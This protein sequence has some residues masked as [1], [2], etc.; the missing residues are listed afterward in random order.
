MD[1]P[2]KRKRK[3]TSSSNTPSKRLSNARSADKPEASPNPRRKAK[4]AAD[5]DADKLWTVRTIQAEKGNKYLIDWEDDPVTGES[6]APTWEPKAY[7]N[8]EAIDDWEG[9]KRLKA[10]PTAMST[11]VAPSPALPT[12]PISSKKRQRKSES[13]SASASTTNNAADDLPSKE[14]PSKRARLSGG[15]G[16]KRDHQVHRGLRRQHSHSLGSSPRRA[17]SEAISAELPPAVEAARSQAS[18]PLADPYDNQEI[19]DSY[20]LEDTPITEELRVS[21][22]PLSK[23]D[24]P[25]HDQL[26][27]ASLPPRT[28]Q[29]PS[30]SPGLTPIATDKDSCLQ[31]TRSPQAGHSTEQLSLA[32]DPEGTVSD[33]H[34]VQESS[35]QL[36][37]PRSLHSEATDVTVEGTGTPALSTSTVHPESGS[38]RVANTTDPP[39]RTLASESSENLNSLGA[40]PPSSSDTFTT[41]EEAPKV[42][43]EDKTRSLS[44]P[45]FSESI[46]SPKQASDGDS[47]SLSDRVTQLEQDKPGES[48]RPTPDKSLTPTLD[49][50]CDTERSAASEP[51]IAE[52][53]PASVEA[54]STHIAEN[55]ALKELS[56]G[57]FANRQT[58]GASDEQTAEKGCFVL[59]IFVQQDPQLAEIIQLAESPYPVEELQPSDIPQTVEVEQSE[60]AG[61]PEPVEATR[62]AEDPGS[63]A[64]RPPVSS[65]SEQVPQQVEVPKPSETF[66]PVA[67]FQQGAKFTEPA[68][69]PQPA[70]TSLPAEIP[71]QTEPPEPPESSH[72]VESYNPIEA[73]QPVGFLLPVETSHQ[74]EPP[75]PLGYPQPAKLPGPGEAPTI[76]PA[77]AEPPGL[78]ESSQLVESLE[79]VD[80]PSPAGTPQL[81]ERSPSA[82][83]SELVRD[84]QPADN[85]PPLGA[86]HLLEPSRPVEALQLPGHPQL[87]AESQQAEASQTIENSLSAELHQSSEEP[88][89]V[90]VPREGQNPSRV[91]TLPP[92]EAPFPPVETPQPEISQQTEKPLLLEALQPVEDPILLDALQENLSLKTLQS[93]EI[94]QRAETETHQQAETPLQGQIPQRINSPR[95]VRA[96]E[97]VESP[98]PIEPCQLLEN[99]LPIA[100]FDQVEASGAVEVPQPTE[101]PQPVEPLKS[102]KIFQNIEPSPSWETSQSAEPSQLE[103][104]P[105]SLPISESSPGIPGGTDPTNREES[106]HFQ[107]AQNVPQAVQIP[108]PSLEE[109]DSDQDY[110]FQTQVPLPL[111]IERERRKTQSEERILVSS[112]QVETQG[113]GSTAA[114]ISSLHI[115]S[116]SPDK[117]LEISQAVEFAGNIRPEPENE[118]SSTAPISPLIT[119]PSQAEHGAEVGQSQNSGGYSWQAAQVVSPFT[120]PVSQIPSNDNDTDFSGIDNYITSQRLNDIAKPP[121]RH[122]IETYNGEGSRPPDTEKIQQLDLSLKT[123]L[124]PARTPSVVE[125][126]TKTV[127]HKDPNLLPEPSE[128]G[129]FPPEHPQNISYPDSDPH[130]RSPPLPLAPSQSFEGYESP[131]PAQTLQPSPDESMSDE[132]QPMGSSPRG[133]TLRE[134]L[135]SLHASRAAKRAMREES[136]RSARSTVSPPRVSEAQAHSPSPHS[137]GSTLTRVND[138]FLHKE[139]PTQIA[140]SIKAPDLGK[141]EFVVPLPINNDARHQYQQTINDHLGDIEAFL[142]AENE[143]NTASADQMKGIL[144]KISKVAI[145]P[146]LD[147][148][149]TISPQRDLGEDEAKRSEE[150][151][152]KISFLRYFLEAIRSQKLH[153]S[154]LTKSK[155]LLDI[156]ELFLKAKRFKFSRPD[157]PDNSRVKTHLKLPGQMTITLQETGEMGAVYVATNADLVIALDRS[158]NPH[159]RHVEVMRSHAFIVG[160]K[161]PVFHLV[162]RNS[163]EHIDLCVPPVPAE[164]RLQTIVYYVAQTRH[165]IG[166]LS[167]EYPTPAS[168][169]DQLARWISSGAEERL[170]PLPSIGSI[171]SIQVP[172]DSRA[173]D[174]QQTFRG[175]REHP[176]K[177]DDVQNAQKR[178]LV[179]ESNANLAPQKK[180]RPGNSPPAQTPVSGESEVSRVYTTKPRASDPTLATADKG[181]P[182]SEERP[183]ETHPTI[184]TVVGAGRK[185]PQTGREVVV[186]Q[187]GQS[188][189]ERLQDFIKDF[190][191]LQTKYEDQVQEMRSLRAE[192]DNALAALKQSGTRR[193]QMAVEIFKLKEEREGA[194]AMLNQARTDLL[195]STR[196]DVAKSAM[197]REQAQRDKTEKERLEKKVGDMNRELDFFRA[198]YQEASSAAAEAGSEAEFLRGEI[199]ILKRKASGEAVKLRQMAISTESERLSRR[200]LELEATLKERNEHLR[201]KEEEMKLLMRGKG[202]V[203]RAG[204]TPKSPKPSRAGSPNPPTPTA[205]TNTTTP[206]NGGY[207]LGPSATSVAGRGG[208]P[209]RYTGHPL[210][211]E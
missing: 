31:S 194:Q 184:A 52:S 191:K 114:P 9:Q 56:Q 130:L 129:I 33:S 27:S 136:M 199:E 71:L 92:A 103:E 137:K 6:Y 128:E 101:T 73:P 89:S 156:L 185:E 172:T 208:H 117:D 174:P 68:E 29:S 145:H 11:A 115:T 8:Q 209:L 179:D 182:S 105:P 162:A 118:G 122:P 138:M 99:P 177:V 23:P 74:P 193:D 91:E 55:A 190:E 143:S 62:F 40:S 28:Q 5:A 82:G 19:E 66:P 149:E 84:I 86:P 192:R 17:A 51:V 207:G 57:E 100:A 54:T 127:N 154:I 160:K 65:R 22:P 169:A 176:G 15:V 35:G 63:E 76:S 81:L 90:G 202:A 144:D 181:E 211:T 25:N 60:P 64:H 39:D 109:L 45:H 59:P 47:C 67:L 150:L 83:P 108:D 205:I 12:E 183:E 112:Y 43:T 124:P 111:N 44:R 175:N 167:P 195:G 75:E 141:M 151:S 50:N 88:D 153:L 107:A 102:V 113:E 49:T 200:I 70:E 178:P 80:T 3:D 38:D 148:N 120:D 203:M 72:I 116:H 69:T 171:R 14:P 46:E 135:N 87:V 187:E 197:D 196:P 34:S 161:C 198:Q 1:A 146:D 18:P 4:Q 106:G 26:P 206:H 13:G 139:L 126:I 189:E 188:T 77:P 10:T 21:V 132:L 97:L 42:A 20:I 125:Q 180:L 48:S 157:R 165:D 104:S 79:Q 147:N 155:R 85:S 164:R 158:F 121:E 98:L 7:A 94:H 41:S 30:P 204:S 140:S 2:P 186:Q 142:K 110:I 133:L 96:P 78:L 16:R 123:P 166:L 152:T 36:T 61:T 163:V 210:P 93:I 170:W 201:R 37:A 32:F 58:E 131:P 95:L 24:K 173:S 134:R 53:L 168:A 119:E 159:D